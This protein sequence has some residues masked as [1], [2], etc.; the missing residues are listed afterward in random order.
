MIV[1]T[2]FLF[3]AAALACDIKFEKIGACANLEFSTA[4][5]VNKN[6][7]FLVSFQND[8]NTKTILPKYNIEVLLWMP[9][10]GHGSKPT[11][12]T[13]FENSGVLY[14]SNVYFIMKGEWEIQIKMRETAEDGT[15]TLVDQ[16][17]HNV[18]L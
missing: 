17:V 1:G 11:A 13:R 7:P 15:E 5:S 14:V 8:D 2:T 4:P 16:T 10:M 3:R 12:V 9:S 6:A 18:N